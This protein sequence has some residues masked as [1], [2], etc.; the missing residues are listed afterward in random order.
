MGA[1]R[2]K[3]TLAI[4]LI[5]LFSIQFISF[6]K[7]LK[8]DNIESLRT[9]LY[10]ALERETALD[11]LDNFINKLEKKIESKSDPILLAYKGACRSMEAKYN[12]WPWDKFSA[13]NTGLQNLNEAVELDSFNIEVRFLR[14]AVLHNIPSFLGYSQDADSDAQ[15][16]FTLITKNSDQ[17]EK[18]L[19]QK[20]AEFLVDSERLD[21]GKSI[22]LTKIYNLSLK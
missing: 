19:I 4:F 13:V 10:S 22:I 7:E 20:V 2:V 14:F 15:I 6:G 11:S 8:S 9:L 3:I 1:T 17:K 21:E 5:I 16:L 18:F 12:F